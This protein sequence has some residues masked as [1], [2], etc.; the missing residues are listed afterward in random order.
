MTSTPPG[1]STRTAS[2]STAPKSSTSVD[3]QRGQHGRERAV[4]ERQGGSIPLHD[5]PAPAPGDSQLVGRAVKPDNGPP[6]GGDG[7]AERLVDPRQQA[8]A[9]GG[10]QRADALVMATVAITRR[11]T[12]PSC[13]P[14][15]AR[16][17]GSGTSSCPGGRRGARQCGLA[18]SGAR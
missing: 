4:G 7:I 12:S 11:R 18:P 15:G 5:P 2:A 13:P 10:E 16:G 9:P 17:Y 3:I 6:G 1:V 8:G 14:H